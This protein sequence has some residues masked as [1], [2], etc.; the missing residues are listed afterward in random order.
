MEVVD[1]STILPDFQDGK[2]YVFNPSV[3]H[4]KENL[5]L[6]VYR[7]FTRALKAPKELDRTKDK[8]HPWL[9]TKQAYKSRWNP[10][11]GG[12]LDG[13][14]CTGCV[15]LKIEGGKISL[16]KDMN[17]PSDQNNY[18]YKNKLVE[19]RDKGYSS[20]TEKVRCFRGV[21][22]RLLRYTQSK[23]TQ[24]LFV[25]SF[26]AFVVGGAVIRASF[27]EIRPETSDP[28]EIQEIFMHDTSDFCE[29]ISQPMEKNWSFWER[30][31]SLM[32]S[33]NISPVHEVVSA[34]ADPKRKII[35][36]VPKKI[37]D[38]V[39]YFGLLEKC[40][41]AGLDEEILFISLTTPAIPRRHRSGRHIG[42]GHLKVK[43]NEHAKFHSG[44]PLGNFYKENLDKFAHHPIYD[45]FMFI[46]EFNTETFE[47]T[48]I[49]DFFIPRPNSSTDVLLSFPSGLEYDQ[50]DNLMIFYGDGDS[51]CK[52]LFIK[53]ADKVL[54]KMLK[55]PVIENRIDACSLLPGPNF[56]LI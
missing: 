53:D 51:F 46:Y 34:I 19:K 23:E 39:D 42:V 32:F 54:E 48:N 13:R 26:N 17:G 22:A 12:E 14:D 56:L 24:N 3:A 11:W 9:D 35:S 50:E 2:T 4:W 1:F 5:Y 15:V 20:Y 25:I 40:Y 55:F 18:R 30:K 49:S 8:N 43:W 16:V 28:D 29:K 31:D 6:C 33:Y 47:L 21:D 38:S 37:F 45:Y 44:S 52:M 27:L 10:G 36:C 7:V 41:N